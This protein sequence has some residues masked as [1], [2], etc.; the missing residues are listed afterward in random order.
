MNPFRVR[1]AQPGAR[2]HPLRLEPDN[3]IDLTRVRVVS[4]R[5]QAAGKAVLVNLPGAR[6]RPAGLV[7]IPA[8]IHPP[9]IQ[10]DAAIKIVVYKENLAL[11]IGINHF[12]KL[13]RT[14]GRQLGDGGEGAARARQ[15]VREHPRPPDILRMP[16]LPFPEL[17]YNHRATHFFSRQQFEV[18]Q[19]LARAKAQPIVGI[20]PEIRGPLPGPAHNKNQPLIPRRNVEIRK[21]VLRR[22]A[23][24]IGDP[25]F[26]L[27][28]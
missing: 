5:P 13:M 12:R 26:A 8:R 14:A 15:I 20:P 25:V 2:G 4:D 1:F 6:V 9:V 22:A 3:N 7:V 10:R 19:L 16:L 21:S 24:G 23:S 27:R 18:S 11:R 28:A 17:Q